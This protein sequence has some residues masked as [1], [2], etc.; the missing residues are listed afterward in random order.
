MMSHGGNNDV[1]SFTRCA[2]YQKLFL[3]NF[4]LLNHIL[5]IVKIRKCIELLKLQ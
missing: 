2:N 3:K 5:P 4:C 1:M